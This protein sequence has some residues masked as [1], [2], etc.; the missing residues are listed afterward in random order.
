MKKMVCHARTLVGHGSGKTGCTDFHEALPCFFGLPKRLAVLLADQCPDR[1]GYLRRDSLG[2][3][4]RASWPQADAGFRRSALNMRIFAAWKALLSSLAGRIFP[5]GMRRGRP[6]W[7][8]RSS[9]GRSIGRSFRP[10]HVYA[11]T[12]A[13]QNR[14]TA[15]AVPLR[16]RIPRT[17]ASFIPRS[18]K[19]SPAMRGKPITRPVSREPRRFLGRD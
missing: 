13:A 5:R 17:R 2:H 1:P 19:L 9:A 18:A 3:A 6:R 16:M 10:A 15:A 7:H 12:M 4:I 14:L 8:H 11:V